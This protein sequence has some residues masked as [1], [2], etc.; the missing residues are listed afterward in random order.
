LTPF[1]VIDRYLEATGPD[2]L[3]AEAFVDLLALDADLL[4][5][6]LV[7]L[8]GVAEPA[9]FLSRLRQLS[10]EHFQELA[11]SQAL[12]VL[13]V[14]GGARV[15]SEPWQSA[16][17]ASFLGEVLA[18]SLNLPGGA[19]RWRVLLA[20]SGINLP[21]DDD[22]AELLAFRGARLELLEDA[23]PRLRIFAVAD[24]LDLLDPEP[25]QRAA[26]SL[27]GIEPL[28]FQ[29][30]LRVAESRARNA[31][32]RLDLEL[33]Q[34]FDRSERLWLRL[35]I[36]LLGRLFSDAPADPSGWPQ[37]AAVHAGVA[38]MLFGGSPRLFLLDQ[39]SRRLDPVDGVGPRIMLDSASSLIARSAR[40]GERV[41][42]YDQFDAAVADRQILRLLH[43]EAAV[44]LP[45]SAAPTEP[46]LGI[47][48]FPLGEDE[49][50]D[51]EFGM[52][53]YARELAR[54]LTAARAR[55]QGEQHALQRYRQREEQRLR[56]LVHEANNP[57]S[58]VQNYLHIL[59]LTLTAEPKAVEQLRLI[60]AEL[61]RGAGVLGQVR[62]VS[63]VIASAREPV[64]EAR[65]VDVSELVARLVEMHRGYAQTRGA[66]ISASLPADVLSLRSDEQRIAQIL[67][68]LMRNALEAS[69]DHSVRVEVLGGAFR[70]GREGV[71][72]VV[73]DTGPGLSREVLE[74]L[75]TPQRTS[76]GGDHAGLGLHIVHRL[77]KEL[78]GSIDV[79]TAAG[80][81]T[82]FTV[83][84]PL[85]S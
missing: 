34:E 79:R 35:R 61:R 18:E 60:G 64:L 67:T 66:E 12:A 69:H 1:A 4:G 77:V 24:V 22:L 39:D 25:A 21:Q 55:Q 37:L 74:R 31:L 17:T 51:D 27:L 62:M 84:L 48:L 16:L 85:S 43:A 54:R 76:K 68:N 46:V 8:G 13:T 78:S 65:P 70:E 3:D 44:C 7:L 83:F 10:P 57:L 20:L 49:D 6:W 11:F 52:V 56:E 80:Q 75:G 19:T 30:A 36:G 71:L 63:D 29:K 42:F 41:E 47:L 26:Q 33:E 53:L 58:I 14:S 5:R 72:L 28:D 50:D 23:D 81:G 9:E 59:Q 45:V 15:G 2:P 40:L 32:S 73:S 38:R 82:N